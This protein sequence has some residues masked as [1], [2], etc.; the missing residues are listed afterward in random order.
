MAYALLSFTIWKKR[1][2]NF[3]SMKVYN[4]ISFQ[5]ANIIKYL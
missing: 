1:R 4:S 3:L 2:Y 5:S